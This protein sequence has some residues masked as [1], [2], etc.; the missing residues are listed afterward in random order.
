MTCNRLLS[1]NVLGNWLELDRL[2]MCLGGQKNKKSS[3]QYI[4][5]D[6]ITFPRTSALPMFCNLFS[7]R[8]M[9]SP[10]LTSLIICIAYEAR[11]KDLDFWP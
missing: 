11:K 8:G 3:Y 9:L 5:A 4:C 6:I 2:E 7:Y 1:I 10:K